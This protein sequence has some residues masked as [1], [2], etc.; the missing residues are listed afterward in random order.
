MK[1]IE[2]YDPAMCCS[3]GVCG[4]VV[5]PELIR[6]SAVVH[7]LKKKEFNV[8]RYNLTSEPDAFVANTLIKQ[9]LTDEGPDVL[10][11]ILLDGQVVKKQSYPSNEELE[12]WTGIP[13]SELT[14]KPKVRI[15]LKLKSK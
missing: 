6:I 1:S 11:V 5:D 8:S 14:Q 9:L 15:E 2:I 4:P 7:N 13:A 10:P 3:T 12:E